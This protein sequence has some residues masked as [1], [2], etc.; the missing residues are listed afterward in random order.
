M[1]GKLEE[2]TYEMSRYRLSILGLCELRWKS[3]GETSTKRVM[4]Y[5][6]V[7][8]RTNTNRALDFLFT[9]NTA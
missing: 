1:A 5:T 8:R 4:N 2:L 3:F 7:Q 6:S 9:R